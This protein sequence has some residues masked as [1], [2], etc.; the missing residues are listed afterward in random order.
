MV[1]ALF[2]RKCASKCASGKLVFVQTFFGLQI[3]ARAA[4]HNQKS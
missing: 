4:A 2:S 3:S 1:S